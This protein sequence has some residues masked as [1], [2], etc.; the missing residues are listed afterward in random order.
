MNRV[1]FFVILFKILVERILSDIPELRDNCLNTFSKRFDLFLNLHKDTV[2]ALDS[3]NKNVFKLLKERGA[4]LPTTSFL[5]R[6]ERNSDFVL[7]QK[8]KLWKFMEDKYGI[9]YTTDYR[10]HL[11]YEPLP[12]ELQRL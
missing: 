6:K 12:V 4:D 8:E 2:S 9:D 1:S 7:S 3:A 5:K 11:D 10:E